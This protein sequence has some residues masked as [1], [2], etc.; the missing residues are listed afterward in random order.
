MVLYSLKTCTFLY[1]W[2]EVACSARHL[3]R[4]DLVWPNFW[5]L[6]WTP[7][8]GNGQLTAKG[9][10][11]GRVESLHTEVEYEPSSSLCTLCSCRGESSLC[12]PMNIY[13]LLV[14]ANLKQTE[15]EAVCSQDSED[16]HC[17]L[18]LWEGGRVGG[19]VPSSPWGCISSSTWMPN[20]APIIQDSLR[21]IQS[22]DLVQLMQIR[23]VWGNGRR[24]P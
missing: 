12:Q 14:W 22:P 5:A 16:L 17:L 3:I 2:V 8:P 6:R 20:R 4:R 10:C 19:A 11:V 18:H 23:M 1:L 13:F 9:R 15:G 21:D 7:A 24:L